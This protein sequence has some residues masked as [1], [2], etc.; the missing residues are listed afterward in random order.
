VF[1]TNATNNLYR[2]SNTNVFQQGGLLYWSTLY[3]EPRMYG[4]KLRYR[5]GG[6]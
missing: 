1:V 5:F 4:V 2:I 3:G 6:E